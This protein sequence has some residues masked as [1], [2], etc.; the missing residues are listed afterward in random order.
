MKIA[1]FHGTA[2]SPSGNWF[3]WLK[4]T[5][6][7]HHQVTIPTLPTPQGQN[8]ESWSKSVMYQIP[9]LAD[10][11]ILI[12][13]S[14]GAAFLPHFIMNHHLTPRQV[15]LVSP[16]YQAIGYPEYDV[17]L[18]T[19]FLDDIQLQNFRRYLI[20]HCM[21]THIFHGDNDPYIS[22]N[23]ARHI[24]G[25]ANIPLTI[26]KGGGHLNAEFGYLKFPELIDALAV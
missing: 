20:D 9:D 1:V 12:G 11:D 2:G 4:E 25:A 23:Q 7:P 18:G 5:L 26:I 6:A 21:N 19:F 15:I 14:C 17:L 8:V 13:H 3:L 10:Y 24:S 16:F 22:V